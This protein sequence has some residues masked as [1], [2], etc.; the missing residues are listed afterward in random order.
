MSETTSI[1]S[2]RDR[3]WLILSVVSAIG[4]ASL[5]PVHGG[6]TPAQAETS[7]ERVQ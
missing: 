6:V 7:Q 3:R 4:G 2:P 1:N 5:A